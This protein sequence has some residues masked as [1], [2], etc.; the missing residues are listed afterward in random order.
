MLKF[1]T[2]KTWE[3]LWKC[4]LSNPSLINHQNLHSNQ[5][6]EVVQVQLQEEFKF[7]STCGA[8]AVC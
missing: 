6:L 5:A 2:G 3:L 7:M 1:Q 8:L 4:M